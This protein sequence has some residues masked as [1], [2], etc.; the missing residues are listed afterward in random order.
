MLNKWMLIGLTVFAL[1]CI[2]FYARQRSL[3]YFPN[4]QMPSLE[5]YHASDMQVVSI[6]TTDHLQLNGWYKPAKDGQPTILYFHG[7]AGNIG[8]PMFLVRKFLQAGLGVLL[9]EYR[10]YG[11][12]PG[13]PSEQGFYTDGRAGVRFLQEQGVNGKKLVL[14]GESLG[15][16]VATEMATETPSCAVILQSPYTSMVDL[17]SYHYP[18]IFMKPWDRFNSLQRIGNLN[19]PLLILHGKLDQVV[20]YAQGLKLY[21]QAK[22]PKEL[23]SF[24]HN[25]HHNLW[26]QANYATNIISFINKHCRI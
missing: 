4:R 19:A 6:P 21:E 5:Q 3:I 17:A 25:D 1:I 23:I 2:V 9:V 12:N 20:P 13:S 16:G 8:G 24:D 11:G 26:S 10:G 14:F 15:A 22:S 18:W 7:N